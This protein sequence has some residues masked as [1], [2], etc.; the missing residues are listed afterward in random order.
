MVLGHNG[1]VDSVEFSGVG[2]PVAVVLG[3]ENTD[4]EQD[5][6]HNPPD[7]NSTQGE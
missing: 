7:A 2:D 1:W 3:S 6:V 5:D 4:H